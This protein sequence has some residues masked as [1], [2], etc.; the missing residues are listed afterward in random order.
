VNELKEENRKKVN[1]QTHK[2]WAISR[3]NDA[4]PIIRYKQP[5]KFPKDKIIEKAHLE[6]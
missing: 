6:S 2:S 4:I 3:I 1:Y 5:Q